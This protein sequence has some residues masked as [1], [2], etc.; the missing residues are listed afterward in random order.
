MGNLAT[1]YQSLGKFEQ[2]KMLEVEVLGKRRELLGDSHPDT[3][4]AM[5]NLAVGAGSI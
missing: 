2:A 1:T 5:G 3:L 4:L